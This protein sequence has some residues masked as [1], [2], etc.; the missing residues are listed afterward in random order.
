MDSRYDK[1]VRSLSDILRIEHQNK[2]KSPRRV[3]GKLQTVSRHREEVKKSS[4]GL[5]KS[6]Q[7][8]KLD[9]PKIAHES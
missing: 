4:E 1:P 3:V 5:K 9:Q 8:K 2:S 6:Q 7:F